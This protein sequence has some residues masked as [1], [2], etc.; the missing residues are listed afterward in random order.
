MNDTRT[1]GDLV[2]DVRKRRGL[3]QRE[4]AD[5]SGV[6]VSLL[7]GNW[8]KATMPVCAWKRRTS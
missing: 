6:S 2:R 7:S 5:L 4:L 1:V 3:S 8:N